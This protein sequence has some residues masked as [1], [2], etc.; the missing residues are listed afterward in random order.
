MIIQ[1]AVYKTLDKI[2]IDDDKG[3]DI[4]NANH[5]IDHSDKSSDS[6]TPKNLSF[7]QCF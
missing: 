3:L 1:D 7:F 4:D 6:N 2:E 5:I